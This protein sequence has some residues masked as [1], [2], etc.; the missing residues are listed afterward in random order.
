MPDW[1]IETLAQGAYVREYHIW[2]KETKEYFGKQLLFNGRVGNSAIV[3]PS[4]Q[5][6]Y[7]QAIN[8]FLHE[9]SV[10]G[11]AEE[12]TEIEAMRSKVNTAKHD[13]GVLVE[14]FVSIDD[15]WAKH[16]AIASFWSKIADH[17]CLI[18]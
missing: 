13:P 10:T 12:M 6:N 3:R 2:E 1:A 16:A 17:E 15:F 4:K 14:H 18:L 7:V 5:E 11:L 9:F 8:R